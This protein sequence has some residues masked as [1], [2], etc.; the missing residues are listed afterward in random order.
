[1]QEKEYN[2]ILIRLDLNNTN[3]KI[4]GKVKNAFLIS[5]KMTYYLSM[6]EGKPLKV[7]LSFFFPLLMRMDS[8]IR[9]LL[10]FL[11]LAIT[12]KRSELTY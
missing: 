10:V 2:I 6:S 12:L 11:D 8:K 9:N 1:M 4:I 3:S 7:L 5:T